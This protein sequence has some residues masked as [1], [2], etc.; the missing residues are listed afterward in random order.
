MC[1]F[2]EIISGLEPAHVLYEDQHTIAFLSVMPINPGHVLVIPKLHE[3]DF[4]NLPEE[5]YQ[6]L[7]NT[8][9][10]VATALNTTYR[11]VKVGELIA[12]WDIPHTHVHVLPMHDYHD[13]TSKKLLEESLVRASDLELL[14]EYHRI[15]D[16]GKMLG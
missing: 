7:M 3:P 14:K 15:K 9:K 12:G 2:C 4:Y 6:A 11:P 8:V 1:K 5:Q 13:I 10:K 16:D